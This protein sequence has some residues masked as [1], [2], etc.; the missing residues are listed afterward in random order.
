MEEALICG[1]SVG[2]AE[3]VAH[4]L[5]LLLHGFDHRIDVDFAQIKILE[6]ARDEN[7]SMDWWRVGAAIRRHCTT[8]KNNE[9]GYADIN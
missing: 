3:E 7:D 1:V 2:P 8:T 9:S 4:S 5:A 6:I